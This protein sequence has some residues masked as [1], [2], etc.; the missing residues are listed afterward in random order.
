MSGVPAAVE[1]A[2]EVKRLALPLGSPV[3]PSGIRGSVVPGGTRGGTE[4]MEGLTG[5]GVRMDMAGIVGIIGMPI[6]R[7]GMEPMPG[8]KE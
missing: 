6:D 3:V 8:E 5:M 2:E 4:G 7:F 1:S